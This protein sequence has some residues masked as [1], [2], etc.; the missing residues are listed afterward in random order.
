MC[1]KLPTCV[2]QDDV[3]CLSHGL[4]GFGASGV[5]PADVFQ[6]C[7]FCAS[8]LVSY[9]LIN[10]HNSFFNVLEIVAVIVVITAAVSM[11][12][13]CT[14]H[15]SHCLSKRLELIILSSDAHTAFSVQG[16]CSY[17]FH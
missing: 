11:Q 1:A 8:V 6:K 15:L 13:S 9:V 7:T 17:C 2:L 14:L 16:E 12:I 4:T 5:I 10:D 3:L